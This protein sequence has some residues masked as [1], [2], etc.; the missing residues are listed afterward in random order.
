MSDLDSRSIG[1]ELNKA[2]RP[3]GSWQLAAERLVPST[4]CDVQALQE[5]STCH[6]VFLLSVSL[7]GEKRSTRLT[8]ETNVV[9]KHDLPVVSL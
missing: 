8:M 9:M 6:I 1:R 4:L 7:L 2:E 3:P 5:R